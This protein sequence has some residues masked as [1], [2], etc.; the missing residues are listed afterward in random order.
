MGDR[1]K[2]RSEESESGFRVQDRRR[3]DADGNLRPP[4][5][6]DAPRSAS[7]KADPAE[8]ARPTPEPGP[9]GAPRSDA[10][11]PDADE[12]A[13]SVGFTELVLSIA[14]NALAFLGREGPGD[15]ATVDA[16]K[17]NLRLASQN[18]DILAML[19]A[20]TRGNLSKAESDLLNSVLYDLRTLYLETAKVVG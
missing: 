6:E 20:K 17:V 1:S 12:G 16:P 7:S 9:A 15:D 3:F 10:S 2:D 18:I 11:A 8:A 13:G 14:T 4:E 19:E 5:S